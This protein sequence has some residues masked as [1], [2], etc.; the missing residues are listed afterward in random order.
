MAKEVLLDKVFI[1]KL[2]DILENNY[3]EENFGVKELAASVVLSK[4]QLHR[5][6]HAAFQ[7]STSQYIRE[8][9]LQKAL[10]MLQEDVITA[11]EV[12]YSVGF[13]SPTY[14]NHCFHKY[15]G[16]TPGEA[17]YKKSFSQKKN[18][19]IYKPEQ[20]H[21]P[22][23]IDKMEKG[24]VRL[25]KK[26]I[27]GFSILVII[28]I[29]VFSYFFYT[30]SI[31]KKLF[32]KEKVQ[33]KSIAVLPFKNLSDD[34]T[35]QYFADGVMDDILNHLSAIKDLKVIS[36]TTMDQYRE[37]NKT[38]PKIA[39]EL[40]V[41]YIIESSIQKYGDSV[42]II[43][44]LIDAK[45]DKHIWSKD[46]KREFKNIFALESEIAKQIAKE[47]KATVSPK[48][49]KRI[50]R[51]PTKNMD[52]YNLYLQGKYSFNSNDD[53]DLV[54]YIEYLNKSLVLDP[55]F[56]LAYAALARAK[57][58]R[59]RAHY[60]SAT[61]EEIKDAKALA[62]KSIELDDNARGHASLGWLYLWFEW[63]WEEAEKQF[64]LAIQ[65]NPNYAGGYVYLSELLYNIKGDF[66]EAR[67][68]VDM[69]LYLGPYSYYPRSVSTR[70]YFNEGEFNKSIDEAEKSKEIN[71]YNT[72]A[73]WRNFQSYVGLGKE[74]KALTE[75]I[76]GWGY[77]EEKSKLIIPIRE[78]YDE[79]GINGVYQ[80]LIDYQIENNKGSKNYFSIAE[81]YTFIGDKG[82]TLEYLEIAYEQ[83]SSRIP[84]IKYNP[85]F[86][87]LRT[88]PRFLAILEKMNLGAYN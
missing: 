80:L 20:H 76:E 41:S 23:N 39:K 70:F 87:D 8:F 68:Q 60:V 31:G 16:Y 50:E 62:I 54:K 58:Q 22:S 45:I 42:R 14:F 25:S 4:S 37:T 11:S 65:I 17:K 32:S 86:N 81:S 33:E 72:S 7:K 5:K 6:L 48:E 79:S 43:T 88:E 2:T 64:K 49:I 13:N 18:E 51:V 73:Y 46:F 74:E 30:G 21:S 9:R 35:N 82:K 83:H 36:R 29:F 40:K 3:T 66:K 71:K 57:I 28:L 1:K 85:Y 15:Y 55:K 47:L 61:K 67:K 77:S 24:E 59:M 63:D 38:I 26:K 34:K 52:A 56:A 19:D 69:A 10:K 84:Y 44:Q 12:A 27:L 75:L 78:A 53:D